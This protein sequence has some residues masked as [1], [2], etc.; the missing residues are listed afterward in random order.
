MSI[1]VLCV[2]DHRPERLDS[3]RTVE[4]SGG[5]RL[6][7]REWPGDGRP[8][9]L[10]H[11]LL[12]SSAGWADLAGRT[13]QPCIAID[14]PGFGD[15]PAPTRPRLSAYAEDVLTTLSTLD[16]GS[17]TLVGHSL[18]GGVAAAV[19]E[20]MREEVQALVLCAPAGFGRIPL[21]ELAALPGL[22]TVAAGS[23]P[24]LMTRRLL[25]GAV[26]ASF[27]TSGIGP[28]EELCRRLAAEAAR[29]GPGVRA[30]LEALAASGR[31]SRAF[32][33]RPVGYDGPVTALWGGRDALV[34]AAHVSGV[35]RAL[36]Q[37]RIHVWRGMGH[38]PQRE[39]PAE[40]AALVDAAH[41]AG[42]A[43]RTC[44]RRAVARRRHVDFHRR[45]PYRDAAPRGRPS[46]A[47]GNRGSR[48]ST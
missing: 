46:L 15:S 30:A 25:V 10:L 13:S 8:L 42:C 22:R 35:Q 43:E 41:R 44:E 14:L 20:R 36:P 48:A 19:A 17:F 12:D 33:R 2:V 26:Y 3:L 45:P 9:V 7:V 24:H 11:G 38:H 47:S 23:L 21:A 29:V 5:R 28:T 18:G 34:P 37:A 1:G 6:A 27:V 16:V 40:F 32:H 31:S 4:V 39:R